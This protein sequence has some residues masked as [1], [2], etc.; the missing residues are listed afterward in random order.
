MTSVAIIVPYRP[1]CPHREAARAFLCRRWAEG[2]PGWPVVE[3][4]HTEG[5]WS[6]AKA[7]SAA[8]S[9]TDAEV[10]LIADADVWVRPDA[11]AAAVQQVIGGAAWAVPHFLLHRL[12]EQRTA[13]VLAGEAGLLDVGMPGVDH[14]RQRGHRGG[15]MVAIRRE[16]YLD[17]PQD[18]RHVE[19]G[20]DD[21][22]AIALETVYGQPPCEAADMVHLY[23]PRVP[24]LTRAWV[25]ETHRELYRRY[26]RA[27]GNEL[28]IR[29]ILNE[30]REAV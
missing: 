25:N 13:A 16:V 26:Q 24:R 2:F 23:H 9:A 1:G 29:R 27:R 22:W 4:V 15:G 28:A 14:I 21:S 19:G 11:T 3:G 12:S 6:K 10:L 7:I 8:L 5:R 17:V 20:E 30:I 18:P